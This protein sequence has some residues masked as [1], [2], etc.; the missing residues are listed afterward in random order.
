MYDTSY[1]L[2]NSVRSNDINLLLAKAILL[3]K[4]SKPE[5]TLELINFI[6]YMHNDLSKKLYLICKIIEISS[7]RS[8]NEYKKAES[9][10]KKFINNNEYEE[11]LEYGFIL[12]LAG[13]IYDSKKALPYVIKGIKHFNKYNASIQE[14]H[15]RIELSV[16]YI[17]NE[18]FELA[19]N[20]L[21]IASEISQNQFIEDYIIDNNLAIINLYQNRDIE[22]SYLML[23]KSLSKVQTPFDKLA[24]HINLLI[25]AN[26]IKP[27]EELI[28]TLCQ[29]IDELCCLNNISDIEIKRISYFNLMLSC[30]ILNNLE[31][32]ELYKKCFEKIIVDGDKYDINKRFKLLINNKLNL[33]TE[34]NSVREFITCEL[35][36]WSIEFDNILKNY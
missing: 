34:E 23:K 32:F 8:L 22:K 25:S 16:M 1:S 29:T 5:E 17:Y 19:R 21:T 14:L 26:F 28:L 24:I 7:L 31:K 10:F 4:N 35:S 2:I 20:E 13:T 9:I 30:R 6:Y 12:R 33:L 36:H 27:D 18:D 15:T 3:E 11:L